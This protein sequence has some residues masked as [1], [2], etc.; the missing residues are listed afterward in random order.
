[1]SFSAVPKM[2]R[3]SALL[4]RSVGGSCEIGAFSD[5]DSVPKVM[6]KRAFSQ[7]GYPVHI[8]NS[9]KVRNQ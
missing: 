8:F 9:L 6:K 3:L 4:R 1:M 2:A 7:L 5:A